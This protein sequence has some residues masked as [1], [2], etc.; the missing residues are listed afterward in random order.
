MFNSKSKTDFPDVNPS[1]GNSSIS[2]G[3]VI[4]GDINSSADLR[5]DGTL[6]GNIHSTARVLIGQDGVVEGDIN[7]EHADVLGKITGTIVVK[8]LLNLRGK[9]EMNG[10]VFA[11]RLQVEPTATF[12]GRCQMGANIVELNRDNHSAIAQ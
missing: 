9:G 5:I 7:C 6:K 4:T 1:G 11:G 3:T 8:D 2:K 12:N 10:D